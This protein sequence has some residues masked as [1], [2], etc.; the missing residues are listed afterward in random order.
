M[1]SV[2]PVEEVLP[3]IA[4]ILGPWFERRCARQSGLRRQ[5]VERVASQLRQ[6]VEHEAPRVYLDG[7]E[8]L[9]DAEREF[10]AA[11]AAAR[12]LDCSA[13]P[14]LLLIFVEEKWLLDDAQDRRVQIAE[15]TALSARMLNRS[16]VDRYW[17]SC[18][19]LTL[20]SALT[21]LRDVRPAWSHTHAFGESHHHCGP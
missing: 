2:E 13:L 16:F 12:A 5:R 8:I 15:L 18:P 19:L 4:E 17:S 14:E 20:E 3:S 7:D 11:G 21:R 6:C 9:V 1:Y 10:E